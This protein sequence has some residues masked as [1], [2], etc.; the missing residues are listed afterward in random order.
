MAI[1]ETLV[2]VTEVYPEN[3]DMAWAITEGTCLFGQ[4]QPF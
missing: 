1:K 2:P 4:H 3:Y